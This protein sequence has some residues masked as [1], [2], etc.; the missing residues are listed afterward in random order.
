MPGCYFRPFR[1]HLLPLG[2]LN[3]GV[4]QYP[5]DFDSQEGLEFYLVR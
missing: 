5:R 3:L 4:H 2:Y 1:E